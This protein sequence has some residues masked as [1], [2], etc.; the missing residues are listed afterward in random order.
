[1]QRA[2]NVRQND[3]AGSREQLAKYPSNMKGTT[4]RIRPAAHSKCPNEA[5]IVSGKNSDSVRRPN[6]QA[7]ELLTEYNSRSDEP[8]LKR[9]TSPYSSLQC[10]HAKNAE[11]PSTC[12]SQYSSQ[13]DEQA[14]YGI[15]EEY[16]VPVTEYQRG[17]H[18]VKSNG[19][20]I[21]THEPV[22]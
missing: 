17:N 7:S 13:A 21:T 12:T 4:T 18:Q 19:L 10:V 6:T 11:R 9:P 3:R 15:A 1:V 20:S 2:H 5:Y 14:V 8:T 16:T 22:I